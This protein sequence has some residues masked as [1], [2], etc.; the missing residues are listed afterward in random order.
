MGDKSPLLGS[1][2]G[3][4]NPIAGTF[5]DTRPKIEAAAKSQYRHGAD[6]CLAR[7][8]HG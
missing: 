3:V 4:N 8:H 6:G 7:C 1:G 5:D 2:N